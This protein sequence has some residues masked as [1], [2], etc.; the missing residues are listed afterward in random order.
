MGER[1]W[2]KVRRNLAHLQSKIR[3]LAV[4]VLLGWLLFTLLHNLEAVMRSYGEMC[5]RNL[6]TKVV[7]ESLSEAETGVK[8]INFTNIENKDIVRLESAVLRECQAML[9]KE[10]SERLERLSTREYPVPLGTVLDCPFLMGCGPKIKLR[11]QPVGGVTTDIRSTLQSAG[12]NQVLY[13]VT[14]DLSIQMTVLLPGSV[15]TVSHT[16]QVVLEEILLTGEVPY[17]YSG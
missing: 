10:I 6:L 5:C 13:R 7:S 16:Q 1:K 4:L 15:Q 8:L 17:V 14:L 9:G 2:R 3:F 11:F 12:I